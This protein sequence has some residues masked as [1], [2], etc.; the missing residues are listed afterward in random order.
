MFR[1]VTIAA[2]GFAALPA[3]AQTLPQPAFL[4]QIVVPSGLAID[5]VTFGGISDL[6]CGVGRRR[7]PQYRRHA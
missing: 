1:I 5:G 2:L 6:T 3:A 4:G 7:H